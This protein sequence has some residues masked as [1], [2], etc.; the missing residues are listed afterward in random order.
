MSHEPLV[1]RLWTDSQLPV[2]GAAV[3]ELGTALAGWGVETIRSDAGV[4]SEHWRASGLRTVPALELLAG[5]ARVASWAGSIRLAAV[6][7]AIEDSRS[8]P[9]DAEAAVE[10]LDYEVVESSGC[11]RYSRWNEQSLASPDPAE[12][13]SSPSRTEPATEVLELDLMGTWLVT[14]ISIDPRDWAVNPEF[15]RSF[16]SAF[17]VL[18][19]SDEDGWETALTVRDHVC[20]TPGAQHWRWT[21]READRVRV[22]ADE[23]GSRRDGKYFCQIAGIR[24]WHRPNGAPRRRPAFSTLVPETLPSGRLPDKRGVARAADASVEAWTFGPGQRLPARVIRAGRAQ[25]L[26]LRGELVVSWWPGNGEVSTRSLGPEELV[27]FPPSLVFA[28]EASAESATQ[29]LAILSGDLHSE[30]WA[31]P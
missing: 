24:L 25:W 15:R 10:A 26:V 21:P 6:E 16:P 18:A 31:T 30:I 9:A 2:D 22:E 20:A 11:H 4:D 5:D 13:W 17:R 19:H 8:G 27:T 29:A 3:E 1:A 23:I 14:G 12:G 28:L 7:A